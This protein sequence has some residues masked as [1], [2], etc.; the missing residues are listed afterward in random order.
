[1]T[2]PASGL[3]P[4]WSQEVGQVGGV[5]GHAAQRVG[6]GVDGAS[7]DDLELLR[8]GVPSWSCR[9]TRGPRPHTIVGLGPAADRL[10]AAD[11]AG[12][13]GERPATARTT[14]SRTYAGLVS[15]AA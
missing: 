6:R 15:R 11:D 8:H 1:M 10:G 4:E 5:V 2:N 3:K 9:P 14:A 13:G 7:S 12:G